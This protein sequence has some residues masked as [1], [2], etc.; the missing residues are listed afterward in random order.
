MS[1]GEWFV[2]ASGK[3]AWQVKDR[4]GGTVAYTHVE[5]DAYDI[6]SEHNAHAVLVEALREIRDRVEW[7]QVVDRRKI[8]ADAL[9]KVGEECQS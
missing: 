7:S 6:A 2:E 5:K 3:N 4:D 9:R 1:K 8:A